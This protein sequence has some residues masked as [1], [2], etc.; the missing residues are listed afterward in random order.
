[1]RSLSQN[2]GSNS[3]RAAKPRFPALAILILLAPVAC[4]LGCSGG[5]GSSV[6]PSAPAPTPTPSSVSITITPATSSVLLG[7]TQTF[8]PTVVG[9]TNT[10]VSWSVNSVPGGTPAT[11]TITAAGVYT[12]PQILPALT[13]VTVTAKSVADPTKQAS[14][15]IA[16]LSDITVA[17]TPGMAGVELS[18]P[19]RP[20]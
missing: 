6:I 14:A 7:N 9:S 1:M 11:G 2:A 5:V 16:I 3:R 4:T 8:T 12:A 13:T 10:A 20:Q 17:L 19:P 18:F 15:T